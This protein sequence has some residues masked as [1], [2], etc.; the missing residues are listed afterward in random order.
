MSKKLKIGNIKPRNENV[1]VTVENIETVK[2]G[3]YQNNR[4]S[5]DNTVMPIEYYFCKIISFGELAKNKDQC[6][7][8]KV[9]NFAFISQFAGQVV[10]TVESYTKVVSGYN[11]VAITEDKDMKIENIKPTNDRVLVELIKNSDLDEEIFSS[12]KSDPMDGDTQSGIILEV[13]SNV[14]DYKKGDIVYFEPFCGSLI[15][16]NIKTINHLDILFTV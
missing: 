8:I 4:N 12:Q 6:P 16:K 15:M 3:V 2:D 10:P 11:I 13:G 7:E 14:E 9:G 1:I 5:V